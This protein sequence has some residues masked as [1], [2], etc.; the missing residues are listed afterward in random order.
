MSRATR[1][2]TLTLIVSAFFNYR[3]SFTVSTT[4]V[5]DFSST[6]A[7]AC[8]KCQVN[9]ATSCW[10]CVATELNEAGAIRCTHVT[11]YDCA[12]EGVCLPPGDE[13]PSP[14]Q[15]ALIHSQFSIHTF[16]PKSQQKNASSQLIPP[17]KIDP[18]VIRQIAAVH[19]RFAATLA[20]FNLRGGLGATTAMQHWTPVDISAED[21]E[22]WLKP[23]K[24]SAIFFEGVNE[25]A[26]EINRLILQGKLAPVVY[27]ISVD[28]SE[29]ILTLRV[30]S[31]GS[32]KDPNYSLL[33][34]KLADKKTPDNKW[35]TAKE[36]RIS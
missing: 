22:W 21:V 25:K 31:N 19:P 26:R 1:I 29:Q 4:R 27:A 9:E 16:L 33:Q 23:E 6:V 20:T 10:E 35:R 7:I 36:W 24:D 14:P 30:I 17:L 8:V 2:L 13:S 3:P 18:G 12:V 32:A 28:L 34:I 11:C 5:P 15:T